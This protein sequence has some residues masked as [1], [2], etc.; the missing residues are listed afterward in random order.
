MIGPGHTAIC[1]DARNVTVEVSLNGQQFTSSGV[2]FE[3]YDRTVWKTMAVWP[4]GGP[5][6]GN[7]SLLISGFRLKPLGDVR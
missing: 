5:L 1:T 7:T 6:G 2:K 3:Y 4:R